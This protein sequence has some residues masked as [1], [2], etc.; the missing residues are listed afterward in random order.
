MILSN[1]TF[2]KFLK[3]LISLFFLSILFHVI[4]HKNNLVFTNYDNKKVA[5]SPFYVCF[6]LVI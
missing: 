1:M 6:L 4:T 2:N 5:F 3:Y